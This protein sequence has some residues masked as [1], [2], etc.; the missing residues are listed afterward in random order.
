MSVGS[1]AGA[2]GT[3]TQ[4]LCFW[5]AAKWEPRPAPAADTSASAWPYPAA[6]AGSL[7]IPAAHPLTLSASVQPW[8]KIWQAL[9]LEG[10]RRRAFELWL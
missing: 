7:G 1:S 8:A 4:P 6:G 9:S 10:W 5:P 2:G 3:P